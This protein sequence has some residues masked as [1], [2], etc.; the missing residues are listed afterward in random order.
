MKYHFLESIVEQRIKN[1]NAIALSI[2][3]RK[4]TYDSFLK[5]SKILANFFKKQ[6]KKQTYLILIS[7]KT[8]FFYK[9][10][11]ACF[12]SDLIYTPINSDAPILRSQSII[13]R[14]DHAVIVLGDISYEQARLFLD[15][16]H[17]RDIFVSDFSLYLHLKVDFPGNRYHLI[18]LESDE[19]TCVLPKPSHKAYLLFTSGSTGQPKGVC[20]SYQN[21]N[22]YLSSIYALF[23]CD[24]KAHFAQLSDIGFDV[25]IHEMLYCWSV[26]AALFVYNK[27]D[28]NSLSYFLQKNAITHLLLIPSLIHYIVQEATYLK[29]KLYAIDTMIACGE[30]FPIRYAEKWRQISPSSRIINFYG[31]TEATVSC[32]YHVYS[33]KNNY[34]DMNILPLGCPL[35][36]VRI[37]LSKD[38]EI[39]IS[40][41]QVAS[42]YVFSDPCH[43]MKFKHFKNSFCYATGDRG[44]FHA[45]FGFIFLG[46]KDDQWQLK[47]YRV[48]KIEIEN[49]LR[50]ITDINDICVVPCYDENN[51]VRFLC[52]FSE[53]KCDFE[54]Y[55]ASLQTHLIPEA[56]PKKYF[57][58]ET[59]PRL[60]NGKIN[61]SALY[62][63]ARLNNDY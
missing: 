43:H 10:V 56:V 28:D 12:F 22:A 18:L 17:D 15:N 20:I 1:P 3:E 58:L 63:Y 14:I 54:H 9:T 36:G 62:E 46:R 13:N 52:A 40:G 4:Y 53:S 60:S 23:P 11:L 42:G 5:D 37:T 47:G 49:T 31:P 8:Y 29:I 33:E 61:Y 30:P 2:H 34:G 24:N 27:G 57:H 16:V 7:N 38:G 25:S 32:S 48:E 44:T 51:L 19:L 50:L 59:F 55:S 45:T 21:I 26:G 6:L 39:L 35:P 41:D